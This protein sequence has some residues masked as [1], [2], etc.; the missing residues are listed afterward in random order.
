MKKYF[1]GYYKPTNEEFD[2]IWDKAIIVVDANVLLNLYTY[3]ATTAQE[4]LSL[5][6]EFV[7][8]LWVPHQV[9]LEYH[10]NRCG[11]I[12]KESK[13]YTDIA[14]ELEKVGMDLRAKKQHPYITIELAKKFEGI[15]AEIKKEL[16]EGE[17]KHRNLITTDSIYEKITEL[18]DGKVGSP[19]T[20]EVLESVYKE[21]KT[22]YTGNIPPGF[23]DIKKPEP[24]RYGALVS[25]N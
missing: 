12:L 24:D 11:I 21:G 22:R 2:A 18:F 15:E 14:K 7:N 23:S 13:R 17:R 20:D 19:M 9:A 10:K 5:F 4:V 1:H 16:E 3:S 25:A 8:R 6:G